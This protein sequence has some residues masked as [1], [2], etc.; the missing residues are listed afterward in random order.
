MPPICMPMLPTLAKPQRA[1]VAMEKVRGSESG[2]ELAELGEGD[3]LVDHGAGAEEVADGAGFVPGDADEP[4]DGCSYDAED[5]VER[6]G[7]GDVAVRPGEV[8]DAEHDGVGEADESDEADEHDGDVEGELAAVDGAAG[9]GGDEVFVL[10]LFVGRHVDGA[11]GG[12]DFGLGHQ[13]FGDEDGAGRGHDDGGEQVLGVDAEADVGGHDAA[14]D[15]G[16][17]GGHDDHEFAA[18]CA[19]Q[20]GADGERGFGLAHEDAGGDVRGFGSAGAHGALHDPGDGLDD[21][22][23]ETDVVHD[24]EERGDEDDGGENGEGEGGERVAGSAHA[25]EDEGG[26]V[27]GVAEEAGDDGGDAAEDALAEAPL[28]DEEGEDDLQAEAPGDG[29]PLDGAAIGGEGVGEAEEGD[30]AE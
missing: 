23:H 3:E 4:G 1:K 13:H 20:K 21:L 14:G 5:G 28:D 6:V 2:F 7:E 22:L 16:H 11:G 29:S 18:C 17:A 10:V 15:V 8:G 26:A 27:G 30:E 24:G 25:A 9:D 12:G 19:R